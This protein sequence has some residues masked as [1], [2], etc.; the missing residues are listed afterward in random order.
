MRLYKLLKNY[1]KKNIVAMHMPGHKRRGFTFSRIPY[2]LDITEIDG[3]D[4]LHCPTGILKSCQEKASKLFKSNQSFYLVNG[5]TCGILASIK[6]C[7]D[8][9]DKII[10]PKNCHKSVYHAVELLNLKCVFIPTHT[11]KNNIFK[12]ILLDDLKVLIN[13]NQDAKCVLITS[14]TYEG[15]ISDIKNISQLVHEYNIPLIVDEAHGSHLFLEN[16]S[17]VNNDA[18]IVI[19]SLHKT[20]PSLTQTAILH[21]LSN[22]IDLNKLQHNLSIFMSSSPSYIL[23]SS[24]DE[25]VEYLNKKGRKSYLKLTK[26]LK[27]FKKE[28]EKLQNLQILNNSK[29]DFFDLDLTKIVILTNNTNITGAQL[30]NFLREQKIEL[31]MAYTNYALAYATIFDNK[32]SFKKL[33]NALKKIDKKI[34]SQNNFVVLQNFETKSKLTVYE[35]LSCKNEI[36]NFEKCQNK[37]CAEYV[38]I[39]PPGIPILIPGQ[40]ITQDIYKYIEY[41]VKCGL[42]IKSSKKMLPDKINVIKDLTKN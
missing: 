14:P 35:A 13:E 23:M 5:S 40:V 7:C 38:W 31:E 20:L 25:C 2:K 27:W 33:F 17:A 37:T 39:Y 10:M 16:K 1:S 9:G 11:D 12:D 24:I 26:N 41:A 4:N 19:N 22:R 32:K 6:T 36:I 8:F 18:D 34:L 42:E 30:L 15:V 3:F 29:S 28:C 21:I